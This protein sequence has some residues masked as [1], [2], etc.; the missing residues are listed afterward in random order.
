MS[1][2]SGWHRLFV[3]LA[4]A[5]LTGI[6]FFAV[7]EF[8]KFRGWGVA[9][10]CY[11]LAEDKMLKRV[12]ENFPRF[13]RKAYVDHAE[14]PKGKY[15]SNPFFGSMPATPMELW[16]QIAHDYKSI[17]F[18]DILSEMTQCSKREVS[19]AKSASLKRNINV[20]MH[21]YGLLGLLPLLGL[22]LIGR[23]VAP[24]VIDGFRQGS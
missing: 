18:K 22:Y 23:F 3:C 6:S 17:D 4:V 2:N 13:N 7:P 12:Q 20:A 24:W 5:W 10:G 16:P 9:A 11:E 1:M 19:R 21:Y 8:K 14:Y 15:V